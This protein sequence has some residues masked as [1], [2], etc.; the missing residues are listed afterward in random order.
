MH[1]YKIKLQDAG[2]GDAF[3]EIPDEIMKLMDIK[4]GDGF[5]IEVSEDGTLTLLPLKVQDKFSEL[6]FATKVIT[7]YLSKNQFDIDRKLSGGKNLF[8]KINDGESGIEAVKELITLFEKEEA[9]KILISDKL[10][11][12]NKVKID[13]DDVGTPHTKEN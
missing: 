5:K 10:D 2:D 3:L 9:Q 11:G 1:D 7:R 6:T 12:R 13:L 4:E 8:E